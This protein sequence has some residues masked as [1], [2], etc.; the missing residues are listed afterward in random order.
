MVNRVGQQ[1]GNYRLTRLLGRGSFAEIYLGLHLYLGTQAA[2]KVLHT[3][4]S[5]DDVERFRL[6]ARTVAHLEHP[7]IVRILEF[8]VEDHTPFLVMSY[9]PHGSLRDHYP[10]GTCIPLSTIVRYVKQIA[11]ALQYAHN[12]HLIHRDL[13]PEN[14]LLGRN[15]EVLLSDFGLALIIP[16]SGSLTAKDM[17][18]T[19]PYMAP[20]QLLGKPRQASDQYALGVIVYEWVC[21]LRPFEG[22][23]LEIVTQHLRA[24]PPSLRGKK[25][26]LPSAVEEVV[27]TALAKDPGQR[28]ATV[29]AFATA[30]QQASLA[31]PQGGARWS[32]GLPSKDLLPLD[33]R[34]RA[35]S[36]QHGPL[37]KTSHGERTEEASPASA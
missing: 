26:T 22:S 30:L 5:Q 34:S 19:V 36:E 10:K 27:L 6:E 32:G 8:G 7:N 28:F 25:P 23:A 24:L 35:L 29:R 17:A 12:C 9:A 2:I 14:L 13:K 21:G 18:G 37:P 4:L 33:E 15:Y 16:H 3:Q 31:D 1:F 11:G 20:E